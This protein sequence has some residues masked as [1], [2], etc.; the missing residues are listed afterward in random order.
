M[1]ALL[2][3]RRIGRYNFLLWAADFIALTAAYYLTWLLR[4]RSA[5]GAGVFDWLNTVLGVG[6]AGLLDQSFELFYIAGAPRIILAMMVVLSLLYALRDLYPGVRFLK[7]RPEAWHILVANTMALLSFYAY[8]YMSRNVFH[9]RSYFF[10]LILI[11][12]GLGCLLRGVLGAV[13]GRLYRTGALDARPV[14]V[15][16]SDREADAVAVVLEARR[17]HGMQVAAR[18]PFP[19]EAP[20]DHVLSQLRDE[21]M[22]GSIEAIVLA[23]K[24]LT[25]GHI[26]SFLELAETL[27]VPA[28]VLSDKLDVL[29][30]RAGIPVDRIGAAPI[31]YFEAPSGQCGSRG[32]WRGIERLVAALLLL[33]L[34]PLLLAIGLA[35]RL[36]SRG[37]ALFAQERVG[38]NRVPFTMYKFRTMHEAADE[39]LAQVEAFN[40]SDGALFKM[41]RDPRVTGIGR[42]LRRF[43][44][45]ELPQLI[46]V[47]RGDMAFIG[48]RPL[49]RRDFENYYEAWHYGRHAGLPGLTCLWQVSGRSLVSF[50]DMCIM[51]IYYL[52]NRTWVLDLQILLQTVRAVFF[53]Q[54]AY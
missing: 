18:V 7:P 35:I 30:L 50:E 36:T 48:P 46:N 49:P 1:A 38:V 19:M 11:N 2:K 16:G 13:L 51:D 34:S 33:V 52:R 39:R 25:T 53:A 26:M 24:K 15:A 32:L 47:A 43:S 21:A 5:W 31:V 45:D 6:R 22:D 8:W 20:F 12:I 27:D 44:L 54:G 3:R 29:A 42:V 41:K 40:E 17:P 28:Y 37:G 10:T 9:P 4:F 23:E 14:L